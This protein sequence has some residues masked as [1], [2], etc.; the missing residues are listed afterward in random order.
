MPF[1][2]A[3]WRQIPVSLTHLLGG[4]C[5]ALATACTHTHKW[6]YRPI[7][8]HI[9]F[10]PS[11]TACAYEQQR[12]YLTLYFSDVT[13]ETYGPL[14]FASDERVNTIT[15]WLINHTF[16]SRCVDKNTH[17]LMMHTEITTSCGIV[18]D[19]WS[20]LDNYPVYDGNTLTVILMLPDDLSEFEAEERAEEQRLQAMFDR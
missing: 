14:H 15:E 1:A 13:G 6:F 19:F 20:S 11:N 4:P 16:R 8:N 10:K 12:R 17:A 9:R 3:T 7:R 5:I 18:L 2:M